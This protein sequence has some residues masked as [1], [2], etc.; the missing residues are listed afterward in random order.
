MWR[1]SSLAEHCLITW[2]SKNAHFLFPAIRSYWWKTL[3]LITSLASG[4]PHWWMSKVGDRLV[5]EFPARSRELLMTLWSM[6][7][8]YELCLSTIIPKLSIYSGLTLPW[9]KYATTQLS[10]KTFVLNNKCLLNMF[11]III[12]SVNRIE[13]ERENASHMLDDVTSTAGSSSGKRL[14]GSGR[15]SFFKVSRYYNRSIGELKLTVLYRTVSGTLI[16]PS[17]FF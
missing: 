17:C 9:F 16:L 4:L 10:W 7:L 15:R 2:W 3:T 13:K 12:M 1:H 14:S 5:A 6:F 11:I 8:N